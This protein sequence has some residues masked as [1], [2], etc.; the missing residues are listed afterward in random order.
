MIKNNLQSMLEDGFS[1]KFARFYLNILEEEKNNSAYDSQFVK[2][3]HSKGFRAEVASL[4]DIND[5]NYMNFLSDYDY[6]RIWPINNWTRIWI[7]D[8]LTL[9][10]ML[11]GTEYSGIMPKYYYYTSIDGL[12]TLVDNPYKND[13]A[14]TE[15]FIKVLSEVGEFACKP[16]NGS[17][18][19]GFFKMVYQN[20]KIFV[21]DK[22]LPFNEVSDFLNKNQNYVFTE[23]IKAGGCLKKITPQI[24][25]LRIVTI[26]EDGA[27]PIIVGGYLR[28][29]NDLSVSANFLDLGDNVE[30]YNIVTNINIE[31]GEFFDAQKVYVNRKEKIDVH[32][33]SGALLSGKIENFDKLRQI[34]LEIARRFNNVEYMGFDIGVTENGFKCMEI[35]SHPGIGHM[36][37]FEP[38]YENTYLKKYFQ[39]KINEINNL[40]LV[41]KKKRN[42]ILR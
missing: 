31:T 12:R 36:Q 18:S 8:K 37:M 3:A 1:E 9:K 41:G 20:N 38:F 17:T 34:I 6:Y 23:Y 11:D 21:D 16:C 15:Q 22:E 39:K 7:N 35:N 13:I 24:H 27:N 28:I 42:G 25:T 30:K 26:N 14:D 5:I 40:S 2:W 32:P 10:Y 29:P 33:S 19:V 4:Y